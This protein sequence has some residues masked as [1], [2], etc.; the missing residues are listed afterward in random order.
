MEEIE[1]NLQV[2]PAGE[3]ALRAEFERRG[4]RR[5][6]LRAHYYDTADGLLARSGLALRLRHEGRRWVQ[7]LKAASD[8]AAR[9]EEDNVVVKLASGAAPVLDVWRHTEGEASAALHRALG[10][11]SGRSGLV[12]RCAT[13]IWRYRFDV[14]LPDALI[15]VA[16]DIGSITAG[17]RTLP[18]CEVE[19]ELKEG[20]L[21]SL[22]EWAQSW[23]RDGGLWLNSVS[24]AERGFRLASGQAHGPPVK[25]VAPRLAAPWSGGR[26]LRAVLGPVL[27]QVLANA[28]EL[29]TGSEDEEHVHQLRVGLRRLRTALRELGTLSQ[30]VDP[31]WDESLARTAAA[32][33]VLRDNEAVAGAVEPLLRRVGAPRTRWTMPSAGLA[34][35]D[36]VRERRFQCAL[37]EMLGLALSDEDDDLAVS[38]SKAM[39]HV[40]KRLDQ[41]HKRIV[42]SAQRFESLRPE[43]Q[44]SARKRLKRLRYLAEFAGPACKRGALRRYLD[45]LEPAQEALGIHNDVAV[46][47]VQFRRDA[48]HQPDSLFAAGYLQAHL[49]WTAHL[50]R[51]ALRDVASAP[52]PWHR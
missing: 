26:W 21:A 47:A 23:A 50:A 6:H 4:A 41:L 46:A 39:E 19:F 16:L 3:P 35:G 52:R 45:L 15:E 48:V 28:S 20:R 22:V 10:R 42:H 5:V 8:N 30:R 44:H 29:A 32:L 7:T 51:N 27:E 33:G 1:F 17:A 25:A 13:D 14:R 34:A 40:G 31:T 43:Q 2:P 38:P 12:E 36:I 11:I 9:R 49:T 18:V 37:I 24:K